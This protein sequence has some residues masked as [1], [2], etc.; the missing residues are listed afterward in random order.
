MKIAPVC[1]KCHGN[2]AR[3]YFLSTMT[4]DRQNLL[5]ARYP[6][7]PRSIGIIGMAEN[8]EVIQGRQLLAGKIFTTKDLWVRVFQTRSSPGFAI[9]DLFGAG[10]KVR[11]HKGGLWIVDSYPMFIFFIFCLLSFIFYLFWPWRAVFP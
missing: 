11:C 9:M 6:P 7:P 1:A 5:T 4:T 10:R 8:R 2:S 3:K